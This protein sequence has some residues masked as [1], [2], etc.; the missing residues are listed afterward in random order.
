VRICRE[1]KGAL[2]RCVNDASLGDL[3]VFGGTLPRPLRRKLTF[4]LLDMSTLHDS[5]QNLPMH[6]LLLPK[7]IQ[8]L[9]HVCFTC[10]MQLIQ[11][12]GYP[13]ASREITYCYLRL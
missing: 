10:A 4:V 1:T 3:A 2:V 5:D 9:H 7:R 6:I 11:A 8:F 12:V 13:P